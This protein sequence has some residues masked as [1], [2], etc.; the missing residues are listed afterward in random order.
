MHC[1]RCGLVLKEGESY[2]FHEKVLC[3]DCYF[4]QTNPPKACDPMAVAAATSI[5][6]ELG[7]SGTA[8]LTELQKQIFSIIEQRGKIT[9]EELLK[10]ISIKPEEL[11]SQFAILRHCEL[12]RAFKEGDK[13][14][15][16][17]W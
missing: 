10:K 12:I 5:R 8:G 15:L 9:K 3:E 14:Y 1:E 17:K 11:E 4:Y 6:K 13:V 7:Q 16:T 2:N